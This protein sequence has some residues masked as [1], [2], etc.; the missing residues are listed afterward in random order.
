VSIICLSPDTYAF[1]CLTYL[2]LILLDH[3]RSPR[4]DVEAWNLN[5][6]WDQVFIELFATSVDRSFP[7]PAL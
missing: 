6:L 4:F 5:I 1:W 2:K 7:S 3:V